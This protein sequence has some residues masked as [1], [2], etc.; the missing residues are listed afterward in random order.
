VTPFRSRIVAA[1]FFGLLSLGQAYPYSVA[2]AAKAT[3]H[4]CCCAVMKDGES[5]CH[6]RHG[7]KMKCH[8]E[9]SPGLSAAPCGATADVPSLNFSGEPC[10]P[11]FVLLSFAF[12]T[13]S[14]SVSSDL[15][16]PRFPTLP[17]APPPRA[18]FAA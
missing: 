10:L 7:G 14:F 3:P 13:A 5:G 12:P 8:K 18:G 2:W 15:F 4:A 6:C 11:R 1:L 16:P 9:T 17:E